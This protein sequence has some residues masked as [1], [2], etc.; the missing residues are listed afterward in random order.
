[1]VRRTKD[2]IGMDLASSTKAAGNRTSLKGIVVSHL[3]LSNDVARLWN[4]IEM[5]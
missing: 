3:W 5:E 2:W 1:M 4:R